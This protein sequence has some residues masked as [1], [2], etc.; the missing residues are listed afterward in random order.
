MM[1]ASACKWIASMVA[2]DELSNAGRHVSVRRVVWCAVVASSMAIA[3]PAYSQSIAEGQQ[4]EGAVAATAKEPPPPTSGVAAPAAKV[5]QH[6][7]SSAVRGHGVEDRVRLLTRSLN[8]DSKQ[9][10][11]LRE[12][13][14]EERA[15]IRRVWTDPE[16][17]NQDRVT[18]T[19]AIFNHTKEQIRA[20]LTDEQRKKYPAAVSHDA[21]APAQADR[22]Y[23]IRLTQPRMGQ[24]TGSTH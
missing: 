19:L 7:P 6:H 20:I 8:L 22:D 21:L 1:R 10:P 5:Q 3:L 17:I 4:A 18:P 9:E 15:S 2:V 23:W 16:R 13:L 14:E 11:R 24:D 12:V